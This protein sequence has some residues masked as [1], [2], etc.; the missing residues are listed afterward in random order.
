[1]GTAYYAAKLGL[2]VLMIDKDRLPR[3]RVCGDGMLVQ[4]VAKMERLG[5]GDYLA[6]S[7]HGGIEGFSVRTKTAR[8]SE[9]L[10]PDPCASRGYVIRRSEFEPRI[11]ERTLSAG[12]I[13]REGVEARRV[14]RSPAGETRGI[15]ISDGSGETTRIETP[16][17]VTAGGWGGFEGSKKEGLASMVISRQYFAGMP[18][19]GLPAASPPLYS[20]ATHGRSKAS[21]PSASPRLKRSSTDFPAST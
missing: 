7:H 15:E 9:P 6:E 12:A 3:D 18:D 13:L 14:L 20:R 5:L 10:P 16:M 4:T 2:R 11:M 17:I 21:T 1:M 8:F 19:P